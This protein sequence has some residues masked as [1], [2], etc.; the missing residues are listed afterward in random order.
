MSAPSPVFIGIEPGSGHQTCAL[1]VLDEDQR[2][3]AQGRGEL[4]DALSFAAGVSSGIVAVNGPAMLAR[5][6]GGRAVEK[7]LLTQGA[8]IYKSTTSLDRCPPASRRSLELHQRLAEM[9]YIPYPASDAPRQVLEA[10]AEAAFWLLLG[11]RPLEHGTLEGRL[12]RQLVL[13]DAG[14]PL[15]DAMDFFEEITRYRL[16]RGLLPLENIFLPEELN[17]LLCAH[18]AWRAAHQPE[19]L[20]LLGEPQ[21]GQIVLPMPVGRRPA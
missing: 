8:G 12:Q 5:A 16:L 18:I 13:S 21:E 10:P 1:F 19:S 2:I 3:Q 20:R 17:A 9:G 6:P 15:P 7:E 14:L 4:A 11:Q